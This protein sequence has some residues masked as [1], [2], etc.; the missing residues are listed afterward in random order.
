M[1]NFTPFLLLSLLSILA[2]TGCSKPTATHSVTG[3]V[4]D[5][6]S[7]NYDKEIKLTFKDET[8][9]RLKNKHQHPIF[10]NTPIRIDYNA[11][12]CITKVT[13]LTP[14]DE[15]STI[16]TISKSGDDKSSD[17][18]ILNR[19]LMIQMNRDKGTWGIGSTM[20]EVKTV[21][22]EPDETSTSNYDGAIKW[23]YNAPRT[24]NTSNFIEFQLAG[25]TMRV[26][27]YSNKNDHRKFKVSAIP[28]RVIKEK[29]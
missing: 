10:K 24:I 3:I 15:N 4:T 11:C 8:E 2:V 16:V 13:R 27:G 29:D 20:D 1:K 14:A 28:V 19:P 26:S 7:S 17:Q 5:I 22:G 23:T 25:T 18:D 6:S 9:L 12:Q 21:E